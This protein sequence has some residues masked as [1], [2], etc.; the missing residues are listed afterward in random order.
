MS[1]NTLASAPQR[2]RRAPGAASAAH[3]ASPNATAAGPVAAVPRA[4]EMARP[5]HAVADLTVATMNYSIVLRCKD[6][7]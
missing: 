4:T 2:R 5:T 1:T 3:V 6:K 7:R